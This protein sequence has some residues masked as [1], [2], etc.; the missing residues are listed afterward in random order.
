MAHALLSMLVKNKGELL[1]E[2]KRSF[3][4]KSETKVFTEH[5]DRQKNTGPT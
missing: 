4:L 5:K 3:L 1:L 2:K